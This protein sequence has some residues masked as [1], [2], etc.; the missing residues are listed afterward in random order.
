VTP[1]PGDR[2]HAVYTLEPRGDGT[3]DI[4]I[5]DLRTTA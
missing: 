5:E 3:L 2:I 4:R 1:E